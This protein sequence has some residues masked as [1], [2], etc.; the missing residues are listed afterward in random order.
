MQREL[1]VDVT[2]YD[3]GFIRRG[4]PTVEA[5]R[6]PIKQWQHNVGSTPTLGTN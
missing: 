3:S 1:N 6:V 5:L 2:T 4:S